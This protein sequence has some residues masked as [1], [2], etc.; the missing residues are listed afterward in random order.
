MNNDELDSVKETEVKHVF[1]FVTIDD[2]C[3]YRFQYETGEFD[4]E[5][6]DTIEEAKHS[7]DFYQNALEISELKQENQKL[8]EAINATTAPPV[9]VLPRGELV[10][11]LRATDGPWVQLLEPG[12]GVEFYKDKPGFEVRTLC[13]YD[14]Y[15]HLQAVLRQ[16]QAEVVNLQTENRA[17]Q[18]LATDRGDNYS[19]AIRE[20][21]GLQKSKDDLERQL[22]QLVIETEKRLC[23]ILGRNWSAAG[24]SVDSLLTELERSSQAPVSM[25]DAVIR[26]YYDT[27]VKVTT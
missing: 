14:D 22:Q 10:H 13:P 4:D 20:A 7:L 16:S 1:R 25:R 3:Y 11:Q 27:H 15:L 9:A 18:E 24:I 6:F 5:K 23:A 8:R 19:S 17:L 21:I 12:V 26:H 2:R